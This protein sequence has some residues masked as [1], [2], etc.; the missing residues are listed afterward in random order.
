[1]GVTDIVEGLGRGSATVSAVGLTS[2]STAS[3]SAIASR[4]SPDPAGPS[5]EGDGLGVI[6]GA[7]GG[8]AA[9]PTRTAA[10]TSVA[11]VGGAGVGARPARPTAGRD[12]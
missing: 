12:A 10:I 4:R 6:A 2:V 7:L 11:R 9:Q 5:A 1:M 8:G 3:S